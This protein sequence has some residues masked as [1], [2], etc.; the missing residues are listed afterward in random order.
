MNRRDSIERSLALSVLT[1]DSRRA[2]VIPGPAAPEF[3]E[4]PSA[5]AELAIATVKSLGTFLD[6]N[7]LVA[8]L[9]T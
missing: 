3:A 2:Y 9:T 8:A 7:K 4:W 1:R 6:V 5:K